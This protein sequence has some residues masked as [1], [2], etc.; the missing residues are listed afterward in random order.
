MGT[1]GSFLRH[2]DEDDGVYE[3]E[4]SDGVI[5]RIP[6]EV[7]PRGRIGLRSVKSVAKP[8]SGS[9]RSA[10]SVDLEN[11]EVEKIRRDFEMYRLNK[12]NDLANMQKKVQ[13]FETENRRLRAELQ[14]MQK[15]CSKRL[16]ERDAALKAEHQ[17][18]VRAAAFG[19]DRDKIQRQFK[20]TCL[21]TSVVSLGGQCNVTCLLTSV[22]SLG[23]Q[24]KVMC[25]L[26]SVVYLGGQCKVMCLLTS[27]VSLGGQCKVM[28]LLTSVVSL[29]G[30]CKVMCLLTSVVSLGGQCKVMC[31]L[32]SV[33]SLGGQFQ[34]VILTTCN[35]VYI[36]YIQ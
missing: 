7:K 18:V 26:T 21:L 15:M 6:I 31:L 13:K 27:V 5:K 8:K 14:T 33:V 30:Q 32:T 17:A 25:L 23:G 19:S 3:Y 10:L 35:Y 1:G 24:C 22:V 11:A 36:H 9:L 34:L 16:E 29:G 12:E 20:V 4:G 2:N 28:C